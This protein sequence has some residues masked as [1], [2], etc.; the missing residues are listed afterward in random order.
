[1]LP[2]IQLRPLYHR[3]KECI[4]M[5]FSDNTLH[6]I[7]KKI[8]G[9]RWS[10]S[11]RCWYMPLCKESYVIIKSYLE[12]VAILDNTHLKTYLQQR[13]SF[14]VPSGKEEEQ[15]SKQRATLLLQHP[16]SAEN[17]KAFQA[18]QQLIQLKGYSAST[19]KSYSNEFHFLLRLL[20]SVSVASLSKAHIQSYL[21]WLVN[22]KG[23]S[24]VHVHMAVNAIKFY[25]EHVE[26]RAREFYDLP[27]PKRPSRLPEILAEEEVVTLIRTTKNL[28]HKALLMTSYSA[29]LRVSELVQL[30]VRDID[31]KRMTIHIRE[32]KGKKDRM[33]PLSKIL[34]DTLRQYYKQYKPKEYLFEGENG[35]AYCTRSAQKVLHAAKHRSGIWKKGSIHSLRH[36]YAT[37]LLEGGTD[38]RYIQNF[39][40]HNNLK[41]TMRYTHVSKVKVENIGSPLDKLPW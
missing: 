33:V 1:M 19:L 18:F 25:F 21:L 6:Q 37:H 4:S 2:Q 13:K 22:N 29:G 9:I 39:L 40:G 8:K 5:P 32:G 26:G 24:E 17:H 34:L 10:Q 7:V 16:L 20:A 14:L 12:G 38:I 28:K 30:K 31:P 27:R 11:N 15:L 35:G 3:G 41:T 23:Y 36:S